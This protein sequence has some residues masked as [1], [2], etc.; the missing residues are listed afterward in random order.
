M[1]LSSLCSKVH[2]I[3]MNHNSLETRTADP[4]KDIQGSCTKKT[5]AKAIH[6]GSKIRTREQVEL[7][8]LKTW[9]DPALCK[10]RIYL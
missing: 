6:R 3:W 9:R 1:A 8:P 5:V 7:N 4:L 10:L 2:I